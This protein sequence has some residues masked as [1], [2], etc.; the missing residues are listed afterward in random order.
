[1][2]NVSDIACQYDTTFLVDFNSDG[3]KIP[4]LEVS[5]EENFPSNLSASASDTSATPQR[6]SIPTS[7]SNSSNLSFGS[8]PTSPIYGLMPVTPKHRYCV[9]TIY[10]RRSKTPRSPA[11][12]SG[13]FEN[14]FKLS[15]SPEPVTWFHSIPKEPYGLPLY[16]ADVTTEPTELLKQSS[17]SSL[18]KLFWKFGRSKK[19][20]IVEDSSSSSSEGI[21]VTREISVQNMSVRDI[22][23]SRWSRSGSSMGS[24]VIFW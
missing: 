18:A 1:M 22:K 13:S 17:N 11:I 23:K 3:F 2:G 9:N 16:K 20:N 21:C 19:H 15:Q 12:S 6:L 10:Q 8:S 14:I 24:G 7:I 5:K 4:D